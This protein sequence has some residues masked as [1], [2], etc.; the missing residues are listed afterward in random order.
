MIF[1]VVVILI[2]LYFLYIF[3]VS[4]RKDFMVYEKSS[5]QHH[6]AILIPARNEEQVIGPLIES[7]QKQEYS[8][9]AYDIYVLVNNSQDQTEK[10]ALNQGTRV[11][12]MDRE[13]CSKAEV[14][15]VAFE[16]LQSDS[17]I[18]AYIILDA[19]NLA[20][21][22][23]LEQMN[24]AYG[25]GYQLYQG[26]RT[27]K[28][29]QDSWLSSCYEVF[30][31]LQN[32]VFNHAHMQKGHSASLNG[33]AWMMKRSFLKEYGFPVELLTEDIEL[34][35]I[36]ALKGERI[37]YVHEAFVYD[38]YPATIKMAWI[39]L[40]RWVFG[41]LQCMRRYA[42]CLLKEGVRKHSFVC[43]D[44]FVILVAPILFLIALVVLIGMCLFQD[45]FVQWLF[46]SIGWILLVAYGLIVWVQCLAVRKNGT[47][48]I[49]VWKGIVFFPLFVMLFIPMIFLNLCRK[50]AEWKPVIHDR[51]LKIEDMK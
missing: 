48:L 17:K 21:A 24:R 44:M 8:N 20:D 12:H 50:K 49:R 37:G 22:Q 28:N 1:W 18:E 46:R 45:G 51:K 39:Q 43:L 40:R 29:I 25:H 31:I 26:R 36:A 32:M 15:K 7:L 33:T 9:T 42:Y 13:V 19:D 34:S 35:A 38:E 4:L 14:L 6:F 5:I 47:K 41:Q 3:L 30:Y 10:I 23:F 11:I 16:K 2:L 27:G